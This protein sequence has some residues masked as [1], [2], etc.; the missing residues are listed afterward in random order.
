MA[1]KDDSKEAWGARA[2]TEKLPHADPIAYLGT[3]RHPVSIPPTTHDV[4]PSASMEK[5]ATAATKSHVS[6]RILAIGVGL[7]I[8]LPMAISLSTGD[9]V[10][11][12]PAP[13]AAAVPPPRSPDEHARENARAVPT[14]LPPGGVTDGTL[15]EGEP[16]LSSQQSV[17]DWKNPPNTPTAAMSGADYAAE[18]PASNTSQAADADRAPPPASTQLHGREPADVKPAAAPMS[19]R[20]IGKARAAAAF[21][22]PFDFSAAMNAVAASHIGPTQCGPDASGAAPVA[23]TFAPSGEATHAVIENGALRGTPTGGCVVRELRKVRI[24]PY[25]GDLATVRTSVLLR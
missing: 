6:R 19:T 7:A 18:P 15:P 22:A 4:T 17:A 21:A 5:G 16:P 9:D 11:R 3:K 2:R 13:H 23:I 10:A 20:R 12:A 1:D 24:P 25:E 8:V 14:D